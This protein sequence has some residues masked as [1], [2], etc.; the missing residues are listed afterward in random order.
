MTAVTGKL[1]QYRVVKKFIDI[2]TN[3]IVWNKLNIPLI[4]KNNDLYTQKAIQDKIK[5]CRIVRKFI[6]GKYKYYVQLIMTGIPPI[7][8]NIETGEIKNDVGTGV[9]GID[10]GTRTIAFSSKHDV[11]LLE[12]CPEV[13][14]IE[15]K[16]LILQRKLDRQRRSNNINN[17]NSD[18][19]IKRGVKL[20]W[21]KSNKY[22]K[23]Q[24]ELK[25]IQR[26]QAIIRK[27]SH[28]KLANYI[29]SL[30]D[31]ILV[32]TMQFQGLQKRSK[33][34]TKNKQGKYNKKKRFG[35]SL[36]NKAPAMLIEII[37][38]KLK[39]R[40]LEI[41]KINTQKVKASQYNHFSNEYDKKELKDRWNEDI[42]I[43]RDMYS[44]FLIMNVNNDLETINQDKC[45]ETYDKFKILHDKEMK[46]LREL[47]NNGVKLISSMGI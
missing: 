22:I 40:D 47:K 4:I 42:N 2:H 31:R 8:C 37:N 18:G 29:I 10:I 33:N 13:E 1:I 46:R 44:S 27:Q 16:K 35:K 11:K 36:G 7:K 34:T 26:K 20:N 32:E 25:E 45:T 14:N 41:L 6:R 38:R 24:N 17:Y 19:T 23:T 28:E 21:Y 30:G 3:S 43:Q 15:H 39:Y 9:V 5:Y 12:L